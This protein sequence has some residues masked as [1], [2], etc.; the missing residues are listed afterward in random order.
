MEG[1]VL[2][3][4]ASALRRAVMSCICTM[5]LSASAPA[6]SKKLASSATHTS[7]PSWW[8]Q[9]FVGEGVDLAAVHA[10]ARLGGQR[11]GVVGVHERVEALADQ[12]FLALPE[13]R[14][15]RTVDLAH[16]A[17]G[18][19]QRHADRGVRE[20]AVE[21]LFAHRQRLRVVQRGL[22]R[23]ALDRLDAAA[24]HRLVGLLL[25][26]EEVQRGQQ[27]PTMGTTA[28]STPGPDW[29]TVRNSSEATVALPA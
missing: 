25:A 27:Q 18:R 13:Q 20:G 15:E 1:D 3:A 24:P 14:G 21:A 16:L 2:Q 10:P 12:R 22:R 7:L 11:A 8:R 19:H 26:E 17:F 23:L 6:S 5:R 28:I 4:R 29:P 9:Q